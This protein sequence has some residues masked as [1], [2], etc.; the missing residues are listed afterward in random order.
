[1]LPST[2][3]TPPYERRSLRSAEK[4]AIIAAEQ[5]NL[6]ESSTPKSSRKRTPRAH[7]ALQQQEE[8]LNKKSRAI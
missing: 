1:M 7:K 5:A 8:N 4:V 3:T 2:P 6:S